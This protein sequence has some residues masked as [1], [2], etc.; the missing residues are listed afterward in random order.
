MKKFLLI[1]V[2][3]LSPFA[4]FIL[5]S[6]GGKESVSE[7]FAQTPQ[8]FN[9]Q[10]VVR[11]NSGIPLI[12]QSVGIQINIHQTTSTGTI[13]YTETH[14]LMA[15]NI[16]LINLI[17]GGGVPQNGTLF[18]TIDWSAG[19]YFIEISVVTSGQPLTSMG[20]QQLMSVPYSL[21]SANG[22]P[23]LQ[24][25]TGSSG[26][27]GETGSV[28]ATGDIGNT[29]ATGYGLSGV[30]GSIGATGTSGPAGVIGAS[31]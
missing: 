29:G 28:G 1:T 19:P 24:G 6:L 21:Y 25:I 31:G 30:N 26:S 27:V 20:S 18:N 17:V 2:V 8:G 22:T 15:N 13:V 5:S 16:G 11:N 10:A 4:G 7:V 9:Y 23:G 12:N 3:F 14:T